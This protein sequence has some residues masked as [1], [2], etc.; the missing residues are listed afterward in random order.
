MLNKSFIA[1]HVSVEPFSIA[2]CYIG[3][4]LRGICSKGREENKKREARSEGNRFDGKT[5]HSLPGFI[6]LWRGLGET[7]ASLQG[8]PS[9]SFRWLVMHPK[10]GK[11]H[12]LGDP[13]KLHWTQHSEHEE[14]QKK[15]KIT[16]DHAGVKS[17]DDLTIFIKYIEHWVRCRG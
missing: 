7:L 6:Y 14:K 9:L 5:F 12:T 16:G 11:C 4:S 8:F 3:D 13:S 1:K 10:K 15:R 17:Y 2:S